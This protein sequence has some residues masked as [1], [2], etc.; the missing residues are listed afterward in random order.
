[1]SNQMFLWN[2][3]AVLRIKKSNL[4]HFIYRKLNELHFRLDIHLAWIYNN[5]KKNSKAIGMKARLLRFGYLQI[6]Y[7]I[8]A[9]HEFYFAVKYQICYI[10]NIIERG[11]KSPKLRLLQAIY[12]LINLYTFQHFEYSEFDSEHSQKLCEFY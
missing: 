5:P 1:M 4:I 9:A 7:K 3:M 6:K 2:F 11:K 8:E 10:S 12:N